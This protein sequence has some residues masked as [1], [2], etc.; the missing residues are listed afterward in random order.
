MSKKILQ[1]SFIIL[2]FLVLG[3]QTLI[4]QITYN[5]SA[6]L[7]TLLQQI[8]ENYVPPEWVDT[9]NNME[10]LAKTIPQIY[11]TFL[12]A[13]MNKQEGYINS[14]PIASQNFTNLNREIIFQIP[15]IVDLKN[16]LISNN[17]EKVSDNQL[18]NIYDDA[19]VGII[20][21]TFNQE[22]KKSKGKDLSQISMP[23][24]LDQHLVGGTSF[25]K[26]AK[27]DKNEINLFGEV[28]PPA[29]SNS[30][31][32]SDKQTSQPETK[33]QKQ[34]IQK[35]AI[36]GRWQ[37]TSHEC[38]SSIPDDKYNVIDFR[39][40]SGKN[41]YI[42]NSSAS[43]QTLTIVA[44]KQLDQYRIEYVAYWK[45][46]SIARYGRGLCDKIKISVYRNK[47]NELLLCRGGC[48]SIVASGYIKTGR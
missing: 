27:K 16:S 1:T 8:D 21:E 6:A 48:A 18:L 43:D 9:M 28:A 37:F 46:T 7:E 36:L 32:V 5:N 35:G 24:V 30:P 34:P 17:N 38:M 41:L 25:R 23:S 45:G 40:G 47:K 2:T 13:A 26:V 39:R 44:E 3:S 22:Y 31:Y 33:V 12:G 11:F 29:K 19:L 14:N 4:S 20:N 10:K 15:D 42:G